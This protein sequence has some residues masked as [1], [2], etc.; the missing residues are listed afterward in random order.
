MII[1]DFAGKWIALG[2]AQ[3]WSISASLHQWAADIWD[4]AQSTQR[5]ENSIFWLVLLSH[6]EDLKVWRGTKSQPHAV[7]KASMKEDEA[8]RTAGIRAL[9]PLHTHLYTHVQ[10]P[11]N[12]A[13]YSPCSC[14]TG[15]CVTGWSFF[16]ALLWL[17]AGRWPHEGSGNERW[18][19]EQMGFNTVNSTPTASKHKHAKKKRRNKLN[20]WWSVM[21]QTFIMGNEWVHVGKIPKISY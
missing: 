17:A 19:T 6:G 2:K 11:P 5:P 20:N 8:W 21:Y 7:P 13:Q 14:K 18:K 3:H 1:R 10:A 9:K 16:C 4:L 15:T 12:P